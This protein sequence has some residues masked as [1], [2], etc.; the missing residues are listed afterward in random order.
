RHAASRRHAA[1]R[2]RGAAVDPG[3]D[4]WRR[5]LN[6]GHYRVAGVRHAVFDFMRTVAGKL[7]HR[8]GRRRRLPAATDGL[9]MPQARRSIR[10]SPPAVRIAMAVIDLANPT[11]F[12]KLVE[13]LLPWLALATAVTLAIGLQQALSAP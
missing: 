1:C 4:L 9:T 11:R 2:D 8:P 7:R 5:R 13:R 3:L 6:G 10:L 12:L